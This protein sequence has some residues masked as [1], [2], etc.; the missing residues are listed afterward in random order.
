MAESTWSKVEHPKKRAM[1][2]AYVAAGGNVVAACKAARVGR[3]T[4][5]RWALQ[6]EVY[7]EA[8]AQAAYKAGETLEAEAIR[9]ATQGVRKVIYHQGVPVG[10]ETVYSDTLLIFLLKGHMPQKYKDR[11]A[12]EIS[13]PGGKPI[14]TQQVEATDAELDALA[15]LIDEE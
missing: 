6:D 10:E 15:A 11:V 12:Q 7:A 2:N 5:Y 13:G 3:T 1:L 8:F 4:H 9:R 14:Q